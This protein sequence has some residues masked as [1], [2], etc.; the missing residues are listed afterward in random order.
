MR[1]NEHDDLAKAGINELHSGN[2]MGLITI[3]K[4]YQSMI[5]KHLMFFIQKIQKNS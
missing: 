2:M 3:R 1:N 4:N 5:T